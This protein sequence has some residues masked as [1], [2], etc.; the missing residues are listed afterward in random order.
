MDY[1]ELKI[2]EENINTQGLKMKIINYKNKRDLDVEFEDGYIAY[3]KEYKNFKK[4][5]IQ[6]RNYRN[7]RQ[8]KDRI[9]SKIVNTQGLLIE[10]IGYD[11]CDN[12][13]IKFEDG[14]IKNTT[15][16][17]FKKGTILNYSYPTVNGVGIIGWDTICVDDEG[18]DLKSFDKWRYM[19][20]RCYGNRISNCYKDVIV[21][22]E[23]L[24][25]PNFKKWYDDNFYQVDNEEMQLDKD[26]LIKGNKIYS[27]KTCIFVPSEINAYFTKKHNDKKL[28]MGVYYDKNNDNYYSIIGIDGKHKRIKG[29]Q[30]KSIEETFE[31]YKI[32]KEKDIKR[33][34]DKYKNKIPQKLYDAM[35]KYTIEIDD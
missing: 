23:W 10:V 8:R 15:W 18:N 7:G 1:K 25:Y 12:I 34:A 31:Y 13:T 21:C 35:Y 19:L 32:E 5:N 29:S 9:G 6:N 22:D 14:Y 3:H 27:P 4:G 28:P 33:L 2:G 24:Y 16:R 30:S 26:I 17:D 11:T 20:E